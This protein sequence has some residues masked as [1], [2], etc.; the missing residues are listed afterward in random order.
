MILPVQCNRVE[1]HVKRAKER[2]EESRNPFAAHSKTYRRPLFACL[3][4]SR[5]VF[6]R[7]ISAETGDQRTTPV[8]PLPTDIDITPLIPT[9]ILKLSSSNSNSYSYSSSSSSSSSSCSCSS[10]PLPLPLPIPSISYHIILY[11]QPPISSSIL[12]C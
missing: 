1:D 9:P 12:P 5:S 8:L 6:S 7:A 10:F 2:M 4:C 11:T 3:L